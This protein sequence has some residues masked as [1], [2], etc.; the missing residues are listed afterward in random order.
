MF[1]SL[2]RGTAATAAAAAFLIPSAPA[3]AQTAQAARSVKPAKVAK[4][5]FGAWLRGDRHAAAQVATPA[6][7]G[8][9][10]S[11]AYRAP[12]EF[13]GCAANVCRF[14]HTSV[15]VP[16]GLD[17][18]VMIVSGPKV[19]KVYESRHITKPATAAKH[20]FDAWK[21]HDRYRGLEVAT[22]SVVK[23]LFHT[24]F[25]PAGVTYFF[26]GCGPEPKGTSCAYSYEGGAMLMHLRGSKVR[27][28]EVRSISYIA[29]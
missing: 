16:G 20:L 29:D 22:A 14:V 13:A 7:V 18:I 11:Y 28:Y 10:F 19:V 2:L 8:T 9:L 25:D 4:Q 6:A 17:G 12:D 5:L 23:S 3:S 26:Q 27:G 21:R 1:S 15:S 24:R